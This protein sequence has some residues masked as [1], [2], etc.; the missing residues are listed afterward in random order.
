M[1]T[2]R[3]IAC[4]CA[5]ALA[6]PT[7]ASARVA[8][9]A[10]SQTPPVNR[11]NITYGS[12]EYNKQNQQDLGSPT[13]KKANVYVPPVVHSAPVVAVPKADIKA[14]VYVPPVVSNPATVSTAPKG[15]T[16]DDIPPAI[17]QRH[18]VVPAGKSAGKFVVVNPQHHTAPA[19]GSA[20]DSSDG[21]KIAAV[22]EAGLI[23]A[24]AMG[25]AVAV[26]GQMR[27]RRRATTA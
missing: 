23:A 27:P 15:D 3:M 14:N 9:D 24:I 1:S 6:I 20:D 18:V 26:A 16:K 12:T 13:D 17:S 11:P 21:W 22:A 2:R 25:G 7:A 19:A 8:F 4:A 10:P 5:L